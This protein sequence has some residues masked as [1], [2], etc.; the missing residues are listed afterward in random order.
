M[1]NHT[2]KLSS[3]PV[4]AVFLYQSQVCGPSAEIC[5]YVR[6]NKGKL[7]SECTAEE[8]GR[9]NSLKNNITNK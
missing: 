4:L 9:M 8:N 2:T 7:K 1:K 3:R 5:R 6:N